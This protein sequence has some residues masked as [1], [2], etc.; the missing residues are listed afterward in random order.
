MKRKSI[1]NHPCE[2]PRIYNVP[3]SLKLPTQPASGRSGVSKSQGEMSHGREK[4][5]S[6]KIGAFDV[7]QLLRVEWMPSNARFSKAMPV[8]SVWQNTYIE[9]RAMYLEEASASKGSGKVRRNPSAMSKHSYIIIYLDLRLPQIPPHGSVSQRLACHWC[10]ILTAE[11]NV[12]I[13]GV[14]NLFLVSVIA[15]CYK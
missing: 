5:W 11:P 13:E 9:L 3:G 8:D 1:R 12:C 2:E 10:L 14:S 6:S 7:Q 4:P 15:S